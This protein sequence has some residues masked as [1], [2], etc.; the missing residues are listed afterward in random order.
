MGTLLVLDNQL[1]YFLKLIVFSGTACING[2]E[3][4]RSARTSRVRAW[5]VNEQSATV[6]I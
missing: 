6:T 1:R 5:N 2:S 3:M 4:S